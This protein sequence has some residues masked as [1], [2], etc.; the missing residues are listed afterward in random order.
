M[1]DLLYCRTYVMFFD[2]PPQG[3]A[4]FFS[5]KIFYFFSLIDLHQLLMLLEAEQ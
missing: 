3:N 1:E 2:T 4:W 5:L